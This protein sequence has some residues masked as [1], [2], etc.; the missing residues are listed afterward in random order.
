MPTWDAK[1][2]L[3]TLGVDE[4]P[5]EHTDGNALGHARERSSPSTR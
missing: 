2:A 5:F 4:V 3:A 1:R